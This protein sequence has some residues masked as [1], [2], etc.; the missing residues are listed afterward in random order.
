VFAALAFWT[1]MWGPMGAFLA[2][3][4]LIMLLILKEHLFPDDTPQFPDQT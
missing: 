3:P 4:I 2:S 1:W